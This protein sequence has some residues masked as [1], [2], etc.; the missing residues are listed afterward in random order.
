MVSNDG[1][2]KLSD[3]GW[4]IKSSSTQRKTFC[5]TP[6]YFCPE[7]IMYRPFDKKV[8]NW[9][10]GILAYEL[11]CGKPPFYVSS[12]KKMYEMILRH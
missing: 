8:D 3:F 12:K 10:L 7:I 5:G 4:S 11:L 2:L 6:E 9:S 1:I